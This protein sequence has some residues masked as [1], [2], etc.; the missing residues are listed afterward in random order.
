MAQSRFGKVGP[1]AHHAIFAA[2]LRGM[3]EAVSGIGEQQPSEIEAALTALVY[4]QF[5]ILIE[6]VYRQGNLVQVPFMAMIEPVLI[7][8]SEARN[9]CFVQNQSGAAQI[10]IS[11]GQQA[12]AASATPVNGCIIGANLGFYEPIC[13]PQDDLWISA[14]ADNTPG[15]L[16]VA[17]PSWTR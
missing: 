12:N 14:S 6:S 1:Q 10:V 2:N 7:R 15:L 17:L 5:R 9:Y 4:D 11:F 3:A 8:P 16:I 13:V